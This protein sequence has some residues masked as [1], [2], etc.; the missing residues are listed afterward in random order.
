MTREDLEKLLDFMN[1]PIRKKVNGGFMVSCPFKDL[2]LNK[3]DN[4]PSMGI[5]YEKEVFHCFTDNT[6]GDLVYLIKLV[7]N[8]SY[9]QALYIYKLHGGGFVPREV[10]PKVKILKD[11][12]LSAYEKD[13]FKFI[14]FRGLTKEEIIIYEI[15]Y[16]YYGNRITFPIRDF[17]GK[18]YNIYGR[19][20]SNEKPKYKHYFSNFVPF[21]GSNFYEPRK[22]TI[23]LV[24]GVFDVIKLHRLG[25]YNVLGLNGLSLNDREIPNCKSVILF[26]DN[27]KAGTMATYKIAEK[28]SRTHIVMTVRYID[29]KKDPFELDD[30]ILIEMLKYKN[31]I[32]L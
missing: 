1:I 19:T 4:N 32:L 6:K 14:G 2:H 17:D 11:F 13:R 16:D 7:L 22:E 8:C 28:L 18:L 9:E 30:K 24:E 23:I 27:D 21:Y 10:K 26:L 12:Y 29:N 25:I 20:L 31:L 3:T 5:S 15:G